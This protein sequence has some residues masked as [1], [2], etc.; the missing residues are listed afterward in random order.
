[1]VLIQ[2]EP[3]GP[4][5]HFISLSYKTQ[6]GYTLSTVPPAQTTPAA[7]KL[8]SAARLGS[9]AAVRR[10]RRFWLGIMIAAGATGPG[11]EASR[12]LLGPHAGGRCSRPRVL[13][14]ICWLPAVGSAVSAVI[15][16]FPHSTGPALHRPLLLLPPTCPAPH[17]RSRLPRVSLRRRGTPCPVLPLPL[18][19]F[20]ASSP[21][22]HCR[23][24]RR[25]S[26]PEP[27]S[28]H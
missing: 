2:T 8:D 21:G 22:C 3:D 9:D 11:V 4:G 16:C 7:A 12:W 27:A 6:L 20:G 5:S 15:A 1:M 25:A 14:C 23:C 17:P 18:L 24:C 28:G 19:D 10:C 13:R 26:C